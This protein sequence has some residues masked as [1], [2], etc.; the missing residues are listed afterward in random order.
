MI[1]QFLL[2]FIGL[3]L[4]YLEF[5]LPGSILAILGGLSLVASIAIFA[6]DTGSFLYTMIYIFILSSMV[7]STIKVA[8]WRIRTA[9]PGRSINLIS[10]Q[11]GYQAASYD[12]SAI[13]KTGLVVTDLKPGGHILINGK[14]HQAISVS[15]YL[16]KGTAVIV[17]R[18]QEESLIVKRQQKDTSA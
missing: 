15:G 17:L 11:E 2:V 1:L 13:G 12:A 14:R 6:H 10:D 4:I 18:G 7:G 3:T 5:F 16:P 8:L 9:K